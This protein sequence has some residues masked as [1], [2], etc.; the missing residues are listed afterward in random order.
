M[1]AISIDSKINPDLAFFS[2]LL[3][4]NTKFLC[5][6]IIILAVSLA[7]STIDTLVNAISSI[8]VVDGKKVYSGSNQKNFL[9]YLK[10]LWLFYQLYHSL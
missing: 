7:V 6:V 8:V 5:V 1:I 3:Q 4:D 9:Y 10:S 2:V